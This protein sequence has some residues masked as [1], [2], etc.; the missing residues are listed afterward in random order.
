MGSHAW[1][2]NFSLPRS[3]TLGRP[4][5]RTRHPTGRVGR[6]AMPRNRAHKFVG[7]M[8]GLY[9]KQGK[10]Q[11]LYYS[12]SGGYL[13]LGHDLAAARRRL[14]ELQ[15]GRFAVGTVGELLDEFM[16]FREDLSK[17][18]GKPTA[19]TIAGNKRELIPLKAA[20]GRMSV[21]ELQT[22]H[23]WDYMHRYR[24]LE[25]PVR[26]NR[27]VSLLGACYAYGKNRGLVSHNPCVGVQKNKEKPRDRLVTLE[28]LD[29]FCDFAKHNELRSSRSS[30][31][32]QHS[33]EMVSHAFRLA[34]LCGKAVSQILAVQSKHVTSSGIEFDRRK[35]GH[36]TLVE[37]TP[38]MRALVDEILKKSRPLESPSLICNSAGEPYTL[39]GFS[40]LWRRVMAAWVKER[41]KVDPLATKFTFHDLRAMSISTMK[42]QG[43]NPL[44]LTGHA[45]NQ[46]PDRVYDRRRVRKSQAVM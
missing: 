25:A 24:G 29:S 36:S 26:S 10:K 34:F 31:R 11:T 3:G 9:K 14:L 1:R 6:C 21:S 30:K 15:N 18:T 45:S 33:G 8:P 42:A 17:R 13:S 37:W 19:A 39:G 40:S 28:E 22:S 35:G 32:D 16:I 44:E 23:I 7:W 41:R 38:T 46:V 12:L 4:L 43:R 5:L 2:E 27:E 20:F